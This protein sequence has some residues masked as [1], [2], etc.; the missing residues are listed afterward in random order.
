M[1]PLENPTC[2]ST[3]GKDAFSLYF[4]ICIYGRS[5]VRGVMSNIS[6]KNI[7]ILLLIIKLKYVI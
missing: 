1:M 2:H 3:P 6:A 4:S 5:K 7:K